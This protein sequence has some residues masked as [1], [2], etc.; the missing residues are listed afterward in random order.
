MRRSLMTLILLL[1]G[2]L[3]LTAAQ[4]G[5][6]SIPQQQEREI[7]LTG[8]LRAGSSPN[9]FMLD[10]ATPSEMS[11]QSEYHS[12]GQSSSPSELARTETDYMLIPEGR[13]DLQSHVGK[14]VEVKGEMI[15][16]GAETT[17]TQPTERGGSQPQ[18]MVRS[19]REVAQSCD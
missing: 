3:A 17:T 11:G 2:S 16:S 8:C 6:Q 19:I 14:K 13:V 9:S 18:V 12:E 15:G 5:Q 7:T 10:N 1:A 4:S